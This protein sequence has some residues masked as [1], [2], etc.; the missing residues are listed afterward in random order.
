MP[1]QQSRRYRL[2]LVGEP[3]QRGPLRNVPI[4]VEHVEEPG[5]RKLGV[6]FSVD[7]VPWAVFVQQHE[8]RRLAYGGRLVPRE[9]VVISRQRRLQTEVFIAGAVVCPKRRR[10][11]A[12]TD[13]AVREGFADVARAYP[14][15]LIAD[16]PRKRLK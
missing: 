7:T 14:Y 11:V 16:I 2:V 3:L 12:V 1:G 9:P 15:A 5:T 13:G 4:A 10:C 6:V 8:Q